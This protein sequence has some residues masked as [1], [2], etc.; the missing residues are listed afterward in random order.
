MNALKISITSVRFI[1]CIVLALQ[2]SVTRADQLDDLSTVLKYN[3]GSESY[4]KLV[5][6]LGALKEYDAQYIKDPGRFRQAIY[7]NTKHRDIFKGYVQPSRYEFLLKQSEIIQ[8]KADQTT[9]NFLSNATGL[10]PGKLGKLGSIAIDYEKRKG[11]NLSSA[12]YDIDGLVRFVQSN[13]GDNE[14]GK[15]LNN[16]FIKYAGFSIDDDLSSRQAV[17]ISEA[18]KSRINQ[19]GFEQF[20]KE[21][22]EEIDNNLSELDGLYKKSKA[23]AAASSQVEFQRQEIVGAVSLLYYSSLLTNDPQW[24]PLRSVRVLSE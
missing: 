8:L 23:D 9:L 17:V 21:K 6:V 10:V 19:V 16:L 3:L 15:L 24:D 20:L 13:S 12:R 4:K 1:F 22:M 2:S 14:V 7:T 5:H 11:K 18:H